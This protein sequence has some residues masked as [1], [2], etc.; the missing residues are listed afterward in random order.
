[1]QPNFETMTTTELKAY[2]LAH[3]DVLDL[4]PSH[5]VE[6]DVLDLIDQTT[7]QPSSIASIRTHEAFLNSYSSEDEGLYVDYL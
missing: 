2:A 4:L 1:M 3:R 7:I 5:T 6:Q